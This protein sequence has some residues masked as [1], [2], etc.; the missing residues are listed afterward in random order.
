MVEIAHA[1]EA[2]TTLDDDTA[3][4]AHAHSHSHA[5]AHTYPAEK[6][7]STSEDTKATTTVSDIEAK[8]DSPVD[9]LPNGGYGW[10]IV[11]CLLGLNACTWGVNTTYGVFSSYFL[12]FNYYSASQLDYAWVG[13]LSAAIAVSMGPPAN[14]L[15]RRFGIHIPMVLGALGVGLGQCFAGICTSFG[16][17]LACQGIVF[18]IGMG[19]VS[20]FC[21]RWNTNLRHRSSSRPNP[22]LHTGSTAA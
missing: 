5:H 3:K 19:F 17:F 20:L 13:G 12:E 6:V 1:I 16:P 7:P 22:S 8:E 18:G 14:W 15:V 4:H 10:V 9:E 11:V 2:A 21:T